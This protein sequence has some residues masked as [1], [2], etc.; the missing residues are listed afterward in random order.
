MRLP[1]II[2]LTIGRGRELN[3]EG[4]LWGPGALFGYFADAVEPLLASHGKTPA[5]W[6]DRYDAAT[7]RSAGSA[8]P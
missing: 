5:W 1:R 3:A 8:P 4:V 2:V 7:T 6:N